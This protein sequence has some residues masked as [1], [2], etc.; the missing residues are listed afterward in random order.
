MNRLTPGKLVGDVELDRPQNSGLDHTGARR[1]G[2]HDG[3]NAD[4][5][6]TEAISG[7]AMGNAAANSIPMERIYFDITDIVSY[8]HHSRFGNPACS[9]TS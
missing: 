6:Y 7:D 5:E 9:G 4:A 3:R 8:A 2:G 1:R